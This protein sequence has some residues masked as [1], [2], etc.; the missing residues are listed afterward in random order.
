MKRILNKIFCLP[1]LE[2]IVIAVP[3]YVFVFAALKKGSHAPLAYIS[4]LL[5]SYALV[6]TITAFVRL[7]KRVGANFYNFKIIKKI[8]STEIGN[9]IL[10]DDAF[11]S[12]IGLHVGLAFNL[13]YIILNFYYGIKYKS[14]WFA[15]LGFYYV[16]LSAM[17]GVL[18]QFVHANAVRQNIRLE[19]KYYRICGV[20]FLFLNIAL[21]LI[22]VYRVND[23]FASKYSG[24][25]IYGVALYTFYCTVN[26]IVSIIK[27]RKKGSPVLSAVKAA[28]LTASLVSM[29]SLEAAMVAQFSDEDDVFRRNMTAALGAVIC[30]I[31]MFTAIFMII[32]STKKINAANKYN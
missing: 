13:L 14:F 7:C 8:K 29:L 22:V 3:S 1:P 28:S 4:Y 24:T 16:A 25:L 6:I 20:I 23:G 30:T 18:A 12:S 19:Y 5:S 10:S 26:A 15:A 21:S 17:R 27:Y 2:T 11:R 9:M 31:V 32:N